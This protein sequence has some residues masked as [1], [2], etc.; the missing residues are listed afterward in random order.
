MVSVKLGAKARNY[1]FNVSDIDLS[2]ISNNAP[3]ISVSGKGTVTISQ[4]KNNY[5]VLDGNFSLTK[6][7]DYE[8]AIK[9]LDG[10]KVVE[11]GKLVYSAENLGITGADLASGSIFKAFIASQHFVISGNDYNNVIVGADKSDVIKA[12]DGDDTLSGISGRDKLFG[13]AGADILIGG[14]NSDILVGGRGVDT[15][16]FATGDSAD[17]VADFVAK[18]KNHEF[19]DLTSV[20]AVASFDDLSMTQ[21]RSAVRIDFGGDDS[22]TLKDVKLSNLDESDF[23][24]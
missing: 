5:I 15:F 24:F 16:V 3:E 10:I 8:K 20:D 7:P 4:D 9:E 1:D 21:V 22:I 12:R 13:D 23:I 11:D 2:I 17:L 14:E 19:I 18:G 6:F